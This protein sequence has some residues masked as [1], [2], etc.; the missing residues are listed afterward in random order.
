VC[1]L[2]FWHAVGA[3]A[4]RLSTFGTTIR[5]VAWPGTGIVSPV[6]GATE[7]APPKHPFEMA[8]WSS[9]TG[10]EPTGAYDV[11]VSGPFGF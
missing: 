7:N 11:I 6:R 3:P 8:C 10:V 5:V 1:A 2:A 9:V 4:S